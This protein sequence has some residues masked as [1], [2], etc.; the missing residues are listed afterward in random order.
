MLLVLYYGGDM[1]SLSQITVGDLT[2]FMVYAA[3]VGVSIAGKKQLD[4]IVNEIPLV[5]RNAV[6]TT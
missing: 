5:R 2:S 1:V 4:N 3:W 6:K